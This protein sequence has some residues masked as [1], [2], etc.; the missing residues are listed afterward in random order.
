VALIEEKGTDAVRYWAGT[1][2]LGADTAFSPDLLKIGKKLV[3]KLWNATQFAAI[4]LEKLTDA[5][6]TPATDSAITEILDQW[7]LSRL[8]VTVKKATDAFANYEYADALDAT[9][10]FFWADFCD[11]YLELIKKRVYNEPLYSPP[12]PPQAGGIPG[13]AATL[14][15]ASRSNMPF[16]NTTL[17]VEKESPPFTGGLGG[18]REP[19]TPAAQQSAVRAL[20]YCLNT[21]LKLYAPFIP[22]VTEELYSHIFAAEFEAKGSLHARGSWPTP[23]DYP[24]HEASLKAGEVALALLETVR[25]TKSDA[26]KSVKWPVDLLTA[27]TPQGVTEVD[28]ASIAADL[29]GAGNIR[30]LHW[31]AA[32]CLALSEQADAA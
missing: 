19:F 3:T 22:H 14:S 21:I 7:I 30:E 4:H 18:N 32:T 25:K 9:N 11:N 12:T 8:H 6:T 15:Q 29:K 16:Q 23:S 26:A 24:H 2:R 17:A 1:S 20:Y 10:Q 28:L 13:Q 27:A 5:P 31:G